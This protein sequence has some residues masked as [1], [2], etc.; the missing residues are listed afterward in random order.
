M[1]KF[2]RKRGP[3]IN[4]KQPLS[5]LGDKGRIEILKNIQKKWKRL[6][7]LHF[8][9]EAGITQ[10]D[11]QFKWKEL[12]DDYFTD[13]VASGYSDG[14]MERRFPTLS[15]RYQDNV[16]FNSSTFNIY[17][18]YPIV[19]ED[20]EGITA[21]IHQT[22]LPDRLDKKG[23]PNPLPRRPIIQSGFIK[24][25]KEEIVKYFTK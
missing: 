24:I 20:R 19:G 13:K 10:T 21:E 4:G 22:G 12:S 9:A 5:N 3:V 18:E 14:I 16:K 2:S 23:N 15:Q 17:V 8:E 25:A 11:K 1:L 7:Q 6:L